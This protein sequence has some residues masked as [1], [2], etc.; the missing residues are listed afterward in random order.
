MIFYL[1]K[2]SFPKLEISNLTY[3]DDMQT[4][5]FVHPCSS[6]LTARRLIETVSKEDGDGV[7][8]LRRVIPKKIVKKIKE[9]E[10]FHSVTL[11]TYKCINLRK[12]KIEIIGCNNRY[13]SITA[14]KIK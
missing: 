11:A 4:V 6:L 10:T 3:D 13:Y 7:I 14:Y 2:C 1:V 5:T 12:E 9:S 8:M